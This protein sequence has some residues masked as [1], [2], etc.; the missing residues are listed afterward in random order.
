MIL[1]DIGNTHTRIARSDGAAVRILRILPTA[2]LCAADLPAD[3]V[4]AAASVVPEAAARLAGRAVEF[5]TAENCGGL[6]DFSGVDAATLGADR[7]ANAVA[8]AEFYELPALVVDCGSAI[9]CELVDEKR[10]FL[11]GAIAPGRLLQRKA[12]RAG[13]A[14]LPEIAL[15][16]KLPAGPGRT[17]AEAIRLGVDAGAVGMVREFARIMGKTAKLRSV[18]LAG[19]DAGFFASAFP[20]WSMAPADFTLQGIRLAAEKMIFRKSACKTPGR[21]VY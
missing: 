21:G 16:E 6:I 19:G 3:E 8:A 12:L 4:A 11:G 2:E 7:V 10:K 1:L 15:A 18:V 5:V 20:E 13:T 17:T 9:T 14:Q